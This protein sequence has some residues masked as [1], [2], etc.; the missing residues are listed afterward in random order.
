MPGLECKTQARQ[1]VV[2][3]LNELFHSTPPAFFCNINI[4]EYLCSEENYF[5]STKR[6][7]N[8]TEKHMLYIEMSIK[9]AKI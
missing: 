6:N 5:L 1:A 2:I 9:C 4:S 3:A 7:I 8:C